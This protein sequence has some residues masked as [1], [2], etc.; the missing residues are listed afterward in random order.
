A[1]IELTNLQAANFNLDTIYAEKVLDGNA[2]TQNLKVNGV[3]TQGA[4]VS[5]TADKIENLSLNAT[6]KDSFLKDIS[7]KDV[8]VKG[9]GNI[10]LQAK[11]GVSSLDA[12]ASSGKV[13]ADLT[14]ANVKTI[15]GGSGDDKFVIGTSVAN[16]SVDGGAGNDELEIS[17]TGTL[18]PTVANVEKVTLNAT[19]ALT[20]AMDNAKDVSELNIKGDTGGVTVVNSNISA[21]NFLST[22]TG[23]AA[24]TV[25]SANL[26]TINYKAGTEEGEV[27]GNLT[28][29]K[30][31][32]LTVN[33]DALANI[34]DANA[35]VTA[36]VATS[37][38]LNINATKTA[39]SLTLNAAK[40]KDL[41]VT[42]KSVGGFTVKG[43]ANSLDTLSNLNVTTDGVFK[44]ETITGL[45]GVSTVTLSGTNDNSA[46]TLGTLGKAEATQGIA[47][48]ASGLK[49]GLTVGNTSTKGSINI[50]LNAMSGDAT[51]GTADSKTD[52]LT[53]SANGVE[54]NL[55]TEALTSAASTT[56]SLTNVKGASTIASLTA[57][58]ASLA[59]ENTGNVTITSASTASAGD[60]SINANN[61][62]G[63]TTNAITATNGA[64][65]I[66]ANGVSTIAVG[67]LSAK[68][69]TLNAGDASTSVKAGAI[70]AESVNVDL[71]KV[72]GTTTVGKITSDNIVYK[73]SELSAD[74]TGKIE[75]SSKGTT[76]NFKADV[77][78]SLGNDKI[79]L[80]T[81]ATTTS[82]V[83]LSGDLGVGNDIVEINKGAAV[84]ALKSVNL[85]GLTNYASS[86]TELKAAVSDT[87][88]FNGGSG[89]DN[90]EVSG[91][92]ITS[93]I[94]TGDFGE[95]GTDKLT[96]GTSGTAITGAAG[97]AVTID[98]TKVTN[99]DSTEI[100]FTNGAVDM[101]TKALTI[102]GSNSN[103]QVTLKLLAATTK[104]KVDGD[105]G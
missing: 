6:G 16:V 73:A 20:L 74:T 85:S 17:G 94:I 11:A 56:V 48:N 55:K 51:L 81:T 52:N 7:S 61:A 8:S 95:G 76:Q 4:S 31:T 90:V 34:T 82:S 100:N 59:I 71:S 87:L 44:F 40:L 22:A 9:N 32:N 105:L 63:L 25:D 2:D 14:A 89:N 77:T 13:S 50:N 41:V 24:V 42:N 47:L 67:A 72:L 37:M 65:S 83:T 38:S 78:G 79:E 49:A 66:N 15:K 91:T 68:S 26:A 101:S 97:S 33:T 53:I 39:Q 35:I 46:V 1:D 69:V 62:S 19:G 5:I 93:L 104:V 45:A 3:G 88:K 54:G 60:F 29:T 18:K 12:S 102:N 57:A 84:E 103:D 27:K 10:T 75:L 70:S 98:I 28:A 80:T 96:L 58:T 64:I 23:A 43:T 92:D 21:L 36:N 99:V 86:E 30:A